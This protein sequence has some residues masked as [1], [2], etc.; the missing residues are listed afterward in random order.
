MS[1]LFL[2]FITVPVLEILIYI[3][4]SRITGIGVTFALIFGTG[5]IG[6]FLAKREGLQVIRA[7]RRELEYGQ[8]PGN[9]L[10]DGLLVLV[11]GILLITPGLLTDITGFLFLL[12]PTRKMVREFL[13]KKIRKWIDNGQIRFYMWR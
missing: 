2:L 1:R 7:I 5:L 3:E 12:P 8:V 10:L 13:K 4:L 9:H 6:A 11:G